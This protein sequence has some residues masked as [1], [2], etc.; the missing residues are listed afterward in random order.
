MG[1][2]LHFV[3]PEVRVLYLGGGEGSVGGSGTS[4]S[5]S[6]GDAT[7]PTPS[8]VALAS[9]GGSTLLLRPSC[10]LLGFVEAEVAQGGG[11][12]PH[13]CLG[14]DLGLPQA[15]PWPPQGPSATIGGK[16]GPGLGSAAEGGATEGGARA[17]GP[18]GCG[19]GCGDCPG[20]GWSLLAVAAGVVGA[21][22]P[23]PP[24]L[25]WLP[26]WLVSCVYVWAWWLR[27]WCSGG[28]G[29]GLLGVQERGFGA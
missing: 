21:A 27:V 23:T 11:T 14:L 7:L 17:A 19:G 25:C 2:P 1:V 8:V 22:A 28:G 12:Q 15:A 10:H 4:A 20:T 6:V 5:A 26:A 18:E 13:A 3:E 24:C 16:S 29:G 9:V